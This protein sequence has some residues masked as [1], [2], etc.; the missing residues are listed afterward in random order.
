MSAWHVMLQTTLPELLTA[1]I[2]YGNEII[3]SEV[4]SDNVDVMYTLS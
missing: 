4:R 2:D 3:D 1:A